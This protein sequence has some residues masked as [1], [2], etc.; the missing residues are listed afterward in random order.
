[1]A[2][3]RIDFQGRGK[4]ETLPRARVQAMR[5]GVQLALRVARQVCA[6]G[7]ILTQQPIGV[8]MGTA[9]PRAVRIGKEDLERKPLGQLDRKSV[10]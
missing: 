9:L 8:F 2:Q 6:L 3:L 4:V 10:V 1:M 5:D 7:Q